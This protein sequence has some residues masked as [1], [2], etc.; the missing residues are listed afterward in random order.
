MKSKRRVVWIALQVV[1][2]GAT[3]WLRC[4]PLRPL[5]RDTDQ[6]RV[7]PTDPRVRYEP[8]AERVAGRVANAMPAAIQTVEAQLY[9]PFAAPPT[10]YVCATLS[11]FG[12]Y[13]GDVHSAGY[14]IDQRLF[15]SPKLLGTPERIAR[16][17][18]HELAHLH[19][20]Q[21]LGLP[22]MSRLPVWFT[23]GL[24]A[25]VS[26]AG[27]E[28]VTV[29]EARQALRDGRALV[30]DE[31]GTWFHRRSASAFGMTAHL[32][33]RQASMFLGWLARDPIAFR[34]LLLAVQRG[35]DLR[36]AVRDAFGSTVSE[37]WQR[38]VSSQLS[39][40]P[41]PQRVQLC[42][43]SSKPRSCPRCTPA[44]A[45]TPLFS[46]SSGSAGALGH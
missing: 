15:L 13:G 31:T 5:L 39:P 2:L 14:T 19:F 12:A 3:V 22:R 41:F 7:W 18:T 40:G 6:F 36:D 9:R 8:G 38:F 34:Q 43:C 17:L 37:A 25:H 28:N 26:G 45:A 44:V 29:D 21:R 11:T 20:E 33:Y 1:I 27:A 24:A 4:G 16:V 46:K 30:P 32:F 10:V 23:E 42:G 35:V